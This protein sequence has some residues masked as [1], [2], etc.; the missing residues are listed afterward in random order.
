[1]IQDQTLTPLK[2]GLFRKKKI[3]LGIQRTLCSIP[4]AL[5][6]RRAFA[7]RGASRSTIK[8]FTHYNEYGVILYWFTLFLAFFS[9]LAN[10]KKTDITQAV[11][12]AA[13]GYFSFTQARYIPFFLIAAIPAAG[14]LLSKDMLLRWARPLIVIAAIST[15]FF[16]TR[17]EIVNIK[18][19]KSDNWIDEHLFP[20]QAAEFIHANSL[21]GNMY[22]NYDWGGYL[23]WRLG[24]E[25]KVFIDGRALYADI[26]AQSS[27]VD[28]SDSRTFGG[29]PYWKS[30]LASYNVRYIVTPFYQY[31]TGL[32]MPLVN[33]LLRERDW[34]PVFLDFT[35]VIFMKDAPEN[36]RVIAEYPVK[37]EHIRE[38]MLSLLSRQI[39]IAPADALLYIAKG[40]IYMSMSRFME[41]RE[42]YAKALKMAPFNATAKERLLQLNALWK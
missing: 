15:T 8:I 31:R 29:V 16:F 11:L 23:I 18:N 33:A 34:A 24:P 40:E 20:V 25:R 27:I 7:I 35:T 4:Y 32:M 36:Q 3:T 21:K 5:C 17:D 22:N 39:K 19:L 1:M 38:S 14:K 28:T 10:F 42:E 26:Y 13:T 30:V 12:L 2:S 37:K 41:A 9:I 6:K